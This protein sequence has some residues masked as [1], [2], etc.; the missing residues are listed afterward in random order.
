MAMEGSFFTS[1]GSQIH[2][3]VGEGLSIIGGLEMDAAAAKRDQQRVNLQRRE[4]DM[5]EL[6]QAFQMRALAQQQQR[7]RELRN[8][9]ARGV[10]NQRRP[11]VA[12]PVATQGAI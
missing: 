9:L 1:L 11:V 6:L 10:G 4:L 8:A 2:E 5:Q 12:A 7:Q 3:D